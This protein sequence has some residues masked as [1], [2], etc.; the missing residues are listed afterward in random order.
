MTPRSSPSLGSA[1]TEYWAATC[2]NDAAAAL[3]VVDAELAAGRDLADVLEHV[4]TATQHRVG[5]LWAEGSWSVPQEHAATAVSEYVVRHLLARTDLVGDDRAP[6]LLVACAEREWHAL[7]GLVLATLIAHRGR[8]VLHLGTDVSTQS[9]QGALIDHPVRA[10]LVSAS[11]SSSL[12]FVR[13]LVE[14]A[15]GAG[16]PT[17]VGG[18]AFD[19]EGRRAAAVGA[20]AHA[21]DIDSLL[22]AVDA[23]PVHVPPAPP[24]RGPRHNE[25]AM[26]GRRVAAL[27]RTIVHRTT[28]DDAAWAGLDQ[29]QRVD[30]EQILADQVPVVVG[31]VVSALVVDEPGVVGDAL[32]WLADVLGSRTADPAVAGRVLD[33]LVEALRAELRDFPLALEA[34]ASVRTPA[35]TAD[36][37]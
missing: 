29:P 21:G 34:L 23:L 25:A 1:A 4:V 33:R 22:A 36:P 18:Q 2:C 27:S 37:S 10:V 31:T 15:H 6:A 32:G 7:P 17:V 11:I 16:I 9:L 13:R 19:V 24:L 26:L 28:A 14:V 3:A 20:S 30:A 12:P 5:R 8:R 35:T